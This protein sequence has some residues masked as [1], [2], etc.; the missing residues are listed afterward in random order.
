[1]IKLTLSLQT[2][3]DQ[4]WMEGIQNLY[5]TS[6]RQFYP[7]K[8]YD[9]DA[10]NILVD[11]TCEPIDKCDRNQITFKAYYS[12]WLAF[13]TTIVSTTYDLVMPK[14]LTSAVAAAKTC[15]GSGA[16]VH[17][18]PTVDTNTA[19]GISWYTQTFDYAGLEQQLAVL[20]GLNAALV[21]FKR[22]PPFTA[23]TGG[24]SKGNPLA[25]TNSSTEIPQLDK[26]TTGDRA[27]AGILTVVFVAGW[28][29][30]LWWMVKGGAG[31]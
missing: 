8:G 30:G 21:Q 28:S 15:I 26:V 14:M 4:K 10:G 11:I 24:I 18:G 6:S 2:N 23:D 9:G 31:A 3:G 22:Q 19:C 12:T 27:G 1:M 17:Y 13:M 16:N 25:G 5:A 7:V 20:G 29:V